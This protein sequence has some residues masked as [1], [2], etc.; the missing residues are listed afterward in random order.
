MR[1]VGVYV[2]N[3]TFCDAVEKTG[4]QHRRAQTKRKKHVFSAK[5]QAVC[6]GTQIFQ[7][8]NAPMFNDGRA[9]EKGQA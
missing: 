2:K 1:G 9:A 7:T 4:A 8:K 5:R 6:F 3:D